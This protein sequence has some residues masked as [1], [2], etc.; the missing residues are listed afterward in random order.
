MIEWPSK[1]ADLDI[2]YA[3]KTAKPQASSGRKNTLGSFAGTRGKAM[4]IVGLLLELS[5]PAASKFQF[6][7]EAIFLG[8]PAMRI[9]GKRVV[10]AGPTGREPLVGLRIALEAADDAAARPPIENSTAETG[11]S[12][13]RVRVF[14]TPRQAG[15][16]G[17]NLSV[18]SR[19]QAHL[20]KGMTS[21]STSEISRLWQ[22]TAR[23]LTNPISVARASRGQ[24]A[25]CGKYAHRFQVCRSPLPN[26]PLTRA[27][28]LRLARRGILSD[29]RRTGGHYRPPESN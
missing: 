28:C 10:A 5:G 29:G 13:R 26:P 24:G 15:P 6:S 9:K 3:V 1:P 25:R 8:A 27:S 14:S 12:Q 11:S 20:Y 16:V 18:Y 2:Q 22:P 7:T 4:P 23:S 21:R 17:G 19:G